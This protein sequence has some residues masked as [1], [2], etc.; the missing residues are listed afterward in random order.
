LADR[1]TRAQRLAMP[2]ASTAIR[3]LAVDR[4]GCVQP[5]QLR[6]TDPAT[7]QVVQVLV[8]CGATLEHKCRACADRARSLRAQQCRDGWH[9]T[10]EPDPG[11][12]VPDALQ[13]TWLILRAEAQVRRDHALAQG[14]DTADLDELLGDLDDEITAAGVRGRLSPPGLG[15][16]D[17]DHDDQAH[18]ARRSRSTRRRQDA[19]DLPR[20]PV[21]RRTTGR[22]Y[23]APD[24]KRYQPSMFITLTCDSY[25]KVKEDGTPA[26][27]VRYDYQRA[28]R[29]ALHFAALFDRLIQNLRRYLGYDLQ[30]FAAVEPQ[31]RLAPHVHLAIRGT[32]PRADLRQVIA[33][34]YHQVWWPDTSAVRFDGGNLPVWHEPS[35]RYLDPGTGEYLPTWGEALDAIGP[36]DDPLHVARFGPKFDAQGVL[37]GSKD[38]ARCI[39]YLTKY[40]TKQL[41][42]CHAAATAP[43][44]DHA[45]RLAEA[46]RYEPCSPGCANWLRYGVQPDNPRPGLRPGHCRGKAHRRE[47]LGYAGRRVL[48]SRK[49]SGKTLA[50]HRTDRKAWLLAALDLPADDPARY[51]W[52]RVTPGDRDH[53]PPGQALLHVLTDRARWQAALTEA[54]RRAQASADP[55]AVGKAA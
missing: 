27:P 54:R 33:A 26:D 15:G 14:Q 23:E 5:V 32:I 45:N 7:G 42:H 47:H 16:E 4:G 31:K 1:T 29:D 18:P 10:D 46:L 36:H 13:E 44:E 22:V 3:Q 11:P 2:L 49:W 6:R 24:G 53:M 39:G 9:L 20:R 8:P 40:L 37:P 48:V 19:P 41:G 35:G 28:A 30:Y 50:D 51:I 38:S 25:G 17:Q 12:P 43:L 34:T 55:P 21:T 52:E